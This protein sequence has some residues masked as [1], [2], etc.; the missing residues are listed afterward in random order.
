MLLVF[1]SASQSERVVY[2]SLGVEEMRK[3]RSLISFS[4]V[5]LLGH[6]LCRKIELCF[7]IKPLLFSRYI[8][9]PPSKWKH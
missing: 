2:Y 3:G 7:E 5:Y 8:I 6:M 9:I 1:S 4:T